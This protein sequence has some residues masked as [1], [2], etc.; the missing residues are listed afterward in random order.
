[1]KKY[2]VVL[3]TDARYLKP[4]KV[5]WYIQQVL[6]EDAYVQ[7]ALESHGLKVIRMNWDND[8]FDWSQCH[9]ILIRAVW[10]YFHRINEFQPWLK[11]VSTQTSLLNNYD[12]IQWNLNKSYLFDLQNKDVRIPPSIFIPKHTKGKQRSLGDYCSNNSWSE[13]ILKP[14]V[15]GAARHTYRFKRGE[16]EGIENIFAKLH[17]EEDMILQEF[18]SKIISK[19]EA[20]LMFMGGEYTHSVMKRAK[21]GDFRVQDDFGGTVDHYFAPKHEIDFAKKVIDACPYETAY[22]RVDIMWDNFNQVCVSEVELI[23]P[24]LWF[25]NNPK[26]AEVLANYIY[27]QIKLK[28]KNKVNYKVA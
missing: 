15:S 9:Y 28:K 11:K 4:N 21:A 26:S 5:D 23:E 25:R 18:Q 16:H 13:F 8:K 12:L 24:E 19:G 14:A 6:D 17:S 3:L 1:M 10:D 7:N 2:D 27:D 22:A 20:A